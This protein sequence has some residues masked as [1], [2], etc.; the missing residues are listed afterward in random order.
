MAHNAS[1]VDIQLFSLFSHIFGSLYRLDPLCEAFRTFFG[2]EKDLLSVM[3]DP[4]CPKICVFSSSVQVPPEESLRKFTTYIPEDKVKKQQYVIEAKLWQAAVATCA[5]PTYF[6][7]ISIGNEKF[8]DGAMN[9]NCSNPTFL[10]IKEVDKVWKKSP[11]TIDYIISVGTGES[12]ENPQSW[13]IFAGITTVSKIIAAQLSSKRVHE[14]VEPLYE[15]SKYFRFDPPLPKE[16]GIDATSPTDMLLQCVSTYLGTQKVKN[17]IQQAAD[18][19]LIKGIYI[20]QSEHSPD[21]YVHSNNQLRVNLNVL[22]RP[23]ISFKQEFIQSLHH[24]FKYEV[25][26]DNEETVSTNATVNPSPPYIV[27]I[28]LPHRPGSKYKVSIKCQIDERAAQDISGS[29]FYFQQPPEVKL[30]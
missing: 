5:A 7:P 13:G 22:T 14:E 8:E 26:D 3:I 1:L 23:N 12:T 20:E 27:S 21:F 2:S 28:I 11:K 4:Q 18:T 15:P 10:A 24:R 16:I 25:K 19:L 17:R 6:P 9:G 29:P 30:K